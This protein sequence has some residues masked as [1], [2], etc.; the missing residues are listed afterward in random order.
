MSAGPF[1]TTVP[2]AEVRA[3]DELIAR[4][5]HEARTPI[6]AIL[7]WLEL[8]KCHGPGSSQ[9]ARAIEMA[10]R[11]ARELTEIL[12]VAEDAQRAMAGTLELNQA[13]VDLGGLLRSAVDRVLPGA[14]ARSITVDCETAGHGRRAQGDGARLRQ[15]FTRLLAHGVSL[16]GPGRVEVRAEDQRSDVRVDLLFSHLTLSEPLHEAL[17][18]D[19]EWPSMAGPCGE[20]VLDFA[21]ASRV[22]A[23]HQGRLEAAS[24]NGQGTRI[25][26]HLP[27]AASPATA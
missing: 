11:S 14:E 27:L 23:L 6:G 5:A 24:L 13:P 20:A 22:V 21:L 8:L 25:S 2:A 26:A 9:A 17:R 3:R 7:T 19:G 18:D 10:E 15:V 12:T 16:S 1:L 4:V